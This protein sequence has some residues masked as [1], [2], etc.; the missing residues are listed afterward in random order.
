MLLSQAIVEQF[1]H[2]L[3][4]AKATDEIEPTAMTLATTGSPSGRLSARVVLLK[5]F[6]QRGW[7]FYTNTESLKGQQLAE[8]SSAALVFYW[9]RLERQVRIEGEAEAVAPAAADAYFA[10]RGRGSQVGAWASQQSQVLTGGPEELAAAVKYAGQRYH[11]EVVPRPP[12]W[13][14]YRVR[15]HRVEFW[16]G[17]PDRLHDRFVYEAIDGRWEKQWLYP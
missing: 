14:G 3:G 8:H 5:G 15:P 1:E 7:V 16:Q 6:D 13:S 17:R 11:G 9:Q 2:W 12:H 10:S 4:E